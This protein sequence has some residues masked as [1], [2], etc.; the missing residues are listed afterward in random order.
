MRAALPC[1]YGHACMQSSEPPYVHACN[2]APPFCARIQSGTALTCTHAIRH[3]LPVHA[4]N[5]APPLCVSGIPLKCTHAMRQ[6][7]Y[8]H[9]CNQGDLLCAHM[10]SGAPLCAL[11]Q[12]G[13][14]LMCT[15]AFFTPL[16]P[17]PRIHR[18]IWKMIKDKVISGAGAGAG[19]PWLMLPCTI[20][21]RHNTAY[22]TT[23]ERGCVV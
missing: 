16:L 6:P 2:Q 22:H 5:Q 1:L 15:H 3:P 12:S 18:V 7:P 9:A 10:Q 11:M 19:L 20:T 8:V 23:G 13:T 14:S 17:P 21:S 4:Y